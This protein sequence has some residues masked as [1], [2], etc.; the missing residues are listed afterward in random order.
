MT[1][2][3]PP[4][5]RNGDVERRQGPIRRVNRWLGELPVAVTTSLLLLA[6]LFF[7]AGITAV[8]V[9]FGVYGDPINV[10]WGALAV[11]VPAA[12]PLIFYSQLTIRKL[13][14]SRHSLRLLTERL[15]LARASAERESEAKSRF[16]AAMSHELRTPLNAIIGFSEIMRDERLGP[17]EHPRY[18]EYAT[19]IHLS[20]QHLLGII[21]DILDLSKI[22]AGQAALDDSEVCDAAS[23]IAAA[24]RMIQ[25]LADGRDVTLHIPEPQGSI[26]LRAAERMVRQILLNLLSNAVKFTPAGGTVSLAAGPGDDG[27]LAI[28]I[29]DTGIGMS[30]DEIRLALTPF[31]QVRS[32]TLSGHPGTGLG[33]P[34][35]KAMVELHGGRL[36]VRSAPQRG[37]TVTLVFPPDRAAAARAVPDDPAS[38]A[39]AS[40]APVAAPDPP[41]PGGDVQ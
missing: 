8:L 40:D 2:P 3:D 33:L 30:A 1:K 13:R 9:S 4:G 20:G 18:R 12:L 24:A 5:H 19:D 38:D 39:P 32:A 23:A 6:V 29:T 35:A 37:T 36:H 41:P 17:I 27:S 11:T 22:E 15:V 25:P 31:G 26:P 10:I 34:L 16:L 21:N 28:A 7:V 14:T